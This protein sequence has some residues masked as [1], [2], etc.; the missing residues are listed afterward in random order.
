MVQAV[1]APAAAPAQAIPAAAKTLVTLQSVPVQS[2]QVRGR[3]GL[4]LPLTR[5]LSR[6]LPAPQFDAA[7]STRLGRPASPACA[8]PCTEAH[9]S[10]PRSPTRGP[11]QVDTCAALTS[12]VASALSSGDSAA[13]SLLATVFAQPNP[14][15]KA[16]ADALATFNDC[17]K[18]L[19]AFAGEYWLA[20][21]GMHLQR[22]G[23]PASA[24][25]HHSRS[26]CC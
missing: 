14:C 4:S 15:A 2:V 21:G 20:G 9:L 5:A 12:Q 17:P 24:A 23:A 11:E 26:L 8:N 1:K 22:T 18:L 25:A 10:L 16:V 13:P 6:A 19:Q 3:G 7:S